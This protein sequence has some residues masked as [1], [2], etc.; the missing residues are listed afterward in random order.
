[1]SQSHAQRIAPGPGQEWVWENSH[2]PRLEP[3]DKDIN[4]EPGTTGP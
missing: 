1:M 3:V 2:P 4:G